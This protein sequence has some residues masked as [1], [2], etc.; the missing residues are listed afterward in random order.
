MVFGAIRCFDHAFLLLKL[1]L[2]TPSLSHTSGK[3]HSSNYKHGYPQ[4]QSDQRLIF[5]FSDKRAETM[6][7]PPH[8]DRG[9]NENAGGRFEWSE[10]KGGP[11]YDGPTNESDGIIPGRNC[12]PPTKDD[13]AEQHKQ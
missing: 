3:C 12:K 2:D 7:R 1:F 9:Q 6:Q 10:A 5:R 11:N 4:L 8:R 13:T